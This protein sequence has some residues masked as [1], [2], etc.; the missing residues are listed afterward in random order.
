MSSA[1]GWNEAVVGMLVEARADVNQAM[2]NGATALKIS[3]L[4]GHGAVVGMLVE[5]RV[6]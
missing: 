6:D 3:A 2:A 5:A 1:L 4:G